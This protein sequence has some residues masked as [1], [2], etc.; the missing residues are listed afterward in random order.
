MNDDHNQFECGIW[1][2]EGSCLIPLALLETLPV[3]L[4]K[5]IPDEYLDLMGHM[6]IRWYFDMFAKAGRKFFTAHGLGE[7]YFRQG[8]FGVFTLKQYIQYFAEVR[9]GQTVAVH[10]RLIG[11][12]PKRFHFMHFMINETTSQLAATFEALITH[13]DLN[14][15]RAAPMPAHIAQQF[16]ATLDRDTGLDWAAPVCGAMRL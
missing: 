1:D 12:S 3:F 14:L 13:A 9:V 15:R 7:D 4:R 8:N 2:R 6:N 10:T 5:T 11:R 16:D